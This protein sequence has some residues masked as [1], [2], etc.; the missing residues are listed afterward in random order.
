MPAW[1]RGMAVSEFR[2]GIRRGVMAA[3]PFTQVANSVFRDSRLS[4]KAKGIFGYV[5][6][7]ANGWQVTVADLVRLGPDGREAVRTGLGELEA[8][9]YLFRERL[10]RPDGTLGEIVYG[11]TD[12]PAVADNH[13]ERSRLDEGGPRGRGARRRVRGGDPPGRDGG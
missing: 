2:S 1:P 7:H 11:I 12:R 9:G 10:R 3:D 6:T 8:H 5:S 13:A 4:F